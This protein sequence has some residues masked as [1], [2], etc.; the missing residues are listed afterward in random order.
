MSAPHRPLP[1]Q[2]A[3]EQMQ[4]LTEVLRDDV[5]LAVWQRRLEPRVASF[6]AQLLAT[7][8]PLAHSL[9]LELAAEDAEPDLRGLLAGFDELPGCQAFHA[10]VAWLVRAYACL[11]DARLIGLRLRALDRAMCP[12]FHVDRVPL[13]LVTSYAGGGSQWLKEG[14]LP[15]E[16]LGQAAAEGQV[17]PI[18]QLESGHVALLKGE[19]WLGNEGRGLIHR[20]PQ[21]VPGQRRLLLTLDWLE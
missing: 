20:S 19:G 14:V 5:N 18:E 17:A 9:T 10:D 12:R 16:G 3:G 6:A 15:R 4:V 13:R 21:P 8:A 11:L 7:G 2:V 1:R